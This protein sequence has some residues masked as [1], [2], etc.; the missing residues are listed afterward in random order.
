MSVEAAVAGQPVST[1]REDRGRL[2]SPSRLDGGT[3]TLKGV[4][5][6]HVGLTP[7]KPKDSRAGGN[8]TPGDYLL[9]RRRQG[10]SLVL[11][12]SSTVGAVEGGGF[13]SEVW[14]STSASGCEGSGGTR[15]TAANAARENRAS[16]QFMIPH[17][18]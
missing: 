7:S 9:I 2:L 15:D 18:I 16:T 10:P 14:G 4:C 5:R 8:A 3:P 1:S 17:T 13:G 12:F 11:L 6:P